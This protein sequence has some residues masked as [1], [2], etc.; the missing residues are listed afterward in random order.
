MRKNKFSLSKTVIIN[1]SSDQIKEGWR[2]GKGHICIGCKEVYQD[3]Y[4]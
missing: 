4:A 3:I 2:R 1:M